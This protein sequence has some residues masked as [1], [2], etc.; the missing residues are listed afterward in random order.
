MNKLKFHPE[1]VKEIEDA[2]DW[3]G[4][5]S[6]EAKEALKKQLNDGFQK[7]LSFPYSFPTRYKSFRVYTL[8]LFKV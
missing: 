4:T 6:E 7:I 5:Q 2:L 1:A 8:N 3:Y